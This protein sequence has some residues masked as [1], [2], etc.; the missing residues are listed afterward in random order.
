MTCVEFQI[1]DNAFLERYSK[2]QS[3]NAKGWWLAIY[4]T[5]WALFSYFNNYLNSFNLLSKLQEYSAEFKSFINF[6][7]AECTNCLCS[8]VTISYVNSYKI[9]CN[10]ISLYL[11]PWHFHF[12]LLTNY[13]VVFRKLLLEWDNLNW[14]QLILRA[15]QKQKL[16]HFWNIW[17]PLRKRS[18]GISLDTISVLSRICWSASTIGI[19]T[20]DIA[21]TSWP[22][23]DQYMFMSFCDA[24]WVCLSSSRLWM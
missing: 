14:Q 24:I 2:R 23:P 22:S 13:L 3:N 16:G 18:K 12:F 19:S 21:G 6:S 4:L 10:I 1:H 9:I 5:C 7:E 15:Y 8:F 17:S 20:F 11:W